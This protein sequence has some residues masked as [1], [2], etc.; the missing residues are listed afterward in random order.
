MTR[1][2]HVC[3]WWIG[4]LLIS[5]LRRLAENPERILRPLVNPGMTVVDLGS[6]MGFFSIPAARMVGDRGRVVCVDLQERML[7][8]LT[9]RARRRG[10]QPPIE[11]RQCTQE[12]LGIEDL[13]G[14]VGLVIAMHVMHETTDPKAVAEQCAGVLESGG[15]LLIGEPRGHVNDE[16]FAATCELVRSCGLLAQ[17]ALTLR[18]SHTALFKKLA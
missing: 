16:E 5:P 8:T 1:D 15:Q 14:Q 10:L 4:Y 6:A 12:K 13:A 18:K 3:P 9:R 7:K 17:D 11:T 2:H